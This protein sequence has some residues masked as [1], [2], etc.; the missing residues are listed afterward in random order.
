LTVVDD[1]YNAT[2]KILR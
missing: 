1:I 2:R